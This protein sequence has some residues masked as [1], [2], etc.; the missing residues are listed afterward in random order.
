MRR[1]TA[2]WNT[3]VASSAR[4]PP[5]ERYAGAVSFPACHFAGQ[6]PR[7][8]S[9]PGFQISISVEGSSA[10]HKR[11]PQGSAMQRRLFAGKD[12]R[13][14]LG[15]YA[16]LLQLPAH[17]VLVMALHS[18]QHGACSVVA[19]YTAAGKLCR[20]R[21]HGRH[22]GRRRSG[23]SVICAQLSIALFIR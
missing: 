18:A 22:S 12:C 9:V 4:T 17:E 6:L 13:R 10:S 11:W 7:L 3:R 15:G 8:R 5:P 14:T 23:P 2:A 1:V 20:R 21:F 16:Y 19:S